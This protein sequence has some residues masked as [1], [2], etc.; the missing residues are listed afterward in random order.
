[1]L[2]SF[3]LEE[4]FRM[5][6][7]IHQ[8]ESYDI[9][10]IYT[11]IE[12]MFEDLT[13][14]LENK[15]V[16]LKVNLVRKAPPELAVT[17]HPTVVEATAKYFVQRGARVTIADSPGGPNHKGQLISSYEMTGMKQA[18]L[19]SQ[20]EL[21]LSFD[22]RNVAPKNA[23]TIHEFPVLKVFLEADLLINLAKLKTHAIMTYT[24][25]LKNLY[26][27]ISGLTKAA[28]HF[29]LQEP[30]P[31]AEHLV[32]VAE[33]IKPDYH[34]I[35]GIQAME[36]NGPGGGD[37]RECGVL[38]GGKN[39]HALDHT[40]CLIAGIPLDKVPTLIIAKQR[41]LYQE[42]EIPKEI[43]P[44]SRPFVLP[45]SL[46]VTFLPGWLPK[47]VRQVILRRLR[48]LPR[49]EQDKCIGCRRC[50][51]ICPADVIT[52][53]DGKAH[54]TTK[55]C[56]SCFCCSEVCPVKAIGTYRP[57]LSRIM[58]GKISH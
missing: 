25:A 9:E 6:I 17:T 16:V 28:H 42:Y 53:I 48:P 52:M 31:F 50:E 4:G 35:D 20:A 19:N 39:P 56:I 18:A 27:V 21:N 5:S 11:A 45:D 8:I 30:L 49:F 23:R 47:P 12:E 15:H 29:R 3:T 38:L 41:A 51:K 40:A 1:M 37:P 24:G 32:E 26:G 46:N 55:G 7:H 14:P 22:S 34:I 54:H 58:E 44:V 2:Q 43:Q 13:M 36:G 57:L 33:F 10:R